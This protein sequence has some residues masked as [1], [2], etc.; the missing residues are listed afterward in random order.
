MEPV[1]RRSVVRGAALLAPALV[2]AEP[3]DAIALEE[4]DLA[5]LGRGCAPRHEVARLLVRDMSGKHA[6]RMHGVPRTYNWAK[7]P[8]VGVGNHPARH[9]FTAISAWGQIYED[10]HGSPARNV[11]VAC[12]DIGLW[13]LSRSTGKWRQANASRA[14][15]GANYVED[16]AGNGSRPAALRQEPDGSVSA[17]LGGGF[18]FHYYATRARARIDPRDVA[19]VVSVHSARVIMDDP[20]GVD[21]RHL[22]RYLASAGADYWLDRYVGAG[23]G[24]VADVGIGKARYLTSEWLT[25]TMSTLSLRRLDKHSP[26]TCIRGR[27]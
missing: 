13:I 21:E 2:L 20:Y 22:A 6:G 5:R 19:G 16:Y 11:R 26:P 24:T 15:N 27:G 14:I 1:T 10:I 8:R 23:P 12:K 18:N 4:P 9:G 25:L 7:H 17:T 3:H